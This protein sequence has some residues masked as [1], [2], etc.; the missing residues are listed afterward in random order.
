[1]LALGA[2]QRMQPGLGGSPR[3]LG[4]LHRGEMAR[5]K[6]SVLWQPA[7]VPAETIDGVVPFIVKNTKGRRPGRKQEAGG[8]RDREQCRGGLQPSRAPPG[9]IACPAA[10]RVLAEVV[11]GS[12][13]CNT[14]QD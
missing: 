14:H 4:R 1:M 3:S 6:Y 2:R 9:S 11:A 10:R 5:G 8:R 12:P 13:V 7:T